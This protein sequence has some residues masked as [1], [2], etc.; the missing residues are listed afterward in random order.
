VSPEDKDKGI[1]LAEIKYIK[2]IL[3]WNYASTLPASKEIKATK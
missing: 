2:R 3:T 1:A